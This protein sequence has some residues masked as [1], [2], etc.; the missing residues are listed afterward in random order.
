MTEG[1]WVVIIGGLITTAGPG[2]FALIKTWRAQSVTE[3]AGQLAAEAAQRTATIDDLRKLVDDL[4]EQVKNEREARAEDNRVN[5]AALLDLRADVAIATRGMR[6]RDAYISLLRR[7]IEERKEPP[8]P[9]YP[10]DMDG[11]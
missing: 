3:R 6:A 2:I 5:R 4:Q 10:S 9:P 7:H 8:P 11:A 1:M